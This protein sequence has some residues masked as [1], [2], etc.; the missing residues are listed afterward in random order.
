MEMQSLTKA[1][2]IT[3]KGTDW[4]SQLKE[5]GLFKLPE[6]L[7]PGGRV[8]TGAVSTESCPQ[9]DQETAT[10]QLL[11]CNGLR[12]KFP[13][14]VDLPQLLHHNSSWVLA[15]RRALQILKYATEAASIICHPKPIE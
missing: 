10:T 9:P 2:V 6:D 15:P 7:A 12:W 14:L 4:T 3:T 8:T 11:H 13:K 1:D 5:P